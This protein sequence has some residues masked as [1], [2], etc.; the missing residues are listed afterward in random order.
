MPAFPS[1]AIAAPDAVLFREAMSRVTGAVTIVSTAGPGGL[2]GFTATA[3]VSVSDAPPTL[4]VCANKAS[5]TLTA[6]E[7]NGQF[8]VNVLALA[9]RPV[10]E[11]F[12]GRSGLG[13]AARFAVGAWQ[14][15][16]AGACGTGLPLLAGALAAFEC[17]LIEAKPVAGH[18]VLFGA[19]RGIRLAEDAAPLVYARRDYH[20]IS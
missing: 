16:H 15:G 8:A 18:V 19:I 20:S 6:I 13:G 2:S 7:A 9:D 10:A 11:A 17:D 3:M 4:L 1:S 14:T 12:T 5:R